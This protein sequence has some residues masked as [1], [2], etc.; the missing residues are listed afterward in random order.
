M[1]KVLY[2]K[3][4]AVSNAI[5]EFHDF[6]PQGFCLKQKILKYKK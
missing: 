6:V 1:F 4:L 2:A 3:E 5:V